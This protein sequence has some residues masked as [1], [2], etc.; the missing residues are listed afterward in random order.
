MRAH[1]PS[2]A[3]GPDPGSRCLR[4]ELPGPVYQAKTSAEAPSGGS[5]LLGIMTPLSTLRGGVGVTSAPRNVAHLS[6]LEQRGMLRPGESE[7][8]S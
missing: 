2:T 1:P 6:R 4:L 7:L 8:S 5:S 3:W